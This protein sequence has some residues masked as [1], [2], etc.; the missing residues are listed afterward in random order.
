MI[1]VIID[2]AA[3]TTGKHLATAW[4]KIDAVQ[5]LHDASALPETASDSDFLL[6]VD[7]HLQWSW[8]IISFEGITSVYFIDTHID[9]ETRLAHRY[10]YDYCFLA[11]HSALLEFDKKFVNNYYIPLAT[12]KSPAKIHSQTSP[13]YDVSFVG[14]MQGADMSFRRSLERAVSQMDGVRSLFKSD[15]DP[16]EMLAIY[17]DSKVVLNPTVGR[18]VNMR[19]FEALG[20]G[21]Q[22]ISDAIIPPELELN[23][24][25][26]YSVQ[27]FLSEEGLL[28]ST[29]FNLVNNL[30]SHN[31]ETNERVR[32]AEKVWVEH[33]YDNRVRKIINILANA[34]R[35]TR[36]YPRFGFLFLKA[37]WRSELASREQMGISSFS[38]LG[39]TILIISIL[40]KIRAK[41]RHW[42]C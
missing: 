12:F 20:Q 2:K 26:H 15:V 14:R 11:Q 23:S 41:Y 31:D 21:A 38:P 16:E 28:S 5:V 24:D 9:L 27:Q 34:E 18:E 17:A 29:L 39:V 30:V 36:G 6:V 1:Y 40:V 42:A 32:S 25:R 7:P 13:R 33:S 19:L 35:T 4:A 37:L 3:H 8:K 10:C 22:V